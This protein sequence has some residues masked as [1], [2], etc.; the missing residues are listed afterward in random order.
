MKP[1]ETFCFY[2]DNKNMQNNK[3]IRYYLI[4]KIKII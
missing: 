2:D 1:L 4:T 3:I